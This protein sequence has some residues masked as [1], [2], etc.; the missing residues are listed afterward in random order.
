MATPAVRWLQVAVMSRYSDAMTHR[1]TPTRP[2]MRSTTAQ[3]SVSAG[4]LCLDF[5]ATLEHWAEPRDGTMASPEEL[6]AWLTGAGLPSPIGGLTT[7]DVVDADALR[8]AVDSIA[9]AVVGGAV[10]ASDQVRCLN[11]FATRPT[12]VFLLG[13]SG[14]RRVAVE[15]VDAGGSLAVVARDAIHL[16]GELPGTRAPGVCPRGL[17]HAVLRPLRVGRPPL[18]RHEGMWRDRGGGLVP[19]TPRQLARRSG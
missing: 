18:V 1:S 5:L 8:I 12:P 16:F 2:D 6:G 11:R 17:R 15:Q 3:N 13:A 19:E 7:G 4:S 10:P 14:R 9:R